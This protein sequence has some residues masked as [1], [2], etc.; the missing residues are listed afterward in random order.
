MKKS[1]IILRLVGLTMIYLTF[2][3]CKT[4]SNVNCDA[5]GKVNILKIPYTDTIVM[6]S[7]HYHLEEEQL[8]CWVPK[9][10]NIYNDTI[11]LELNYD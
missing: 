5:Y 9:D 4:K 11:Y 8:C 6:E 7:L 2:L 10:T 1:K 3:S